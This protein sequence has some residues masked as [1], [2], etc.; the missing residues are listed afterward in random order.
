MSISVSLYLHPIYILV[1][2]LTCRLGKSCICEH[3]KPQIPSLSHSIWRG[4]TASTAWG[5]SADVFPALYQKNQWDMSYLF[6]GWRILNFHSCDVEPQ[7]FIL[8]KHKRMKQF[9]FICK[10]ALSQ[11]Q[12]PQFSCYGR[13]TPNPQSIAIGVF[14]YGGKMFT[15]RMPNSSKEVNWWVNQVVFPES[16]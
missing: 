16:D 3:T 1:K 12:T 8:A 15:V 4:N 5:S 6:Q 9:I 14:F 11:Q 7:P 13:I 10:A 2:T